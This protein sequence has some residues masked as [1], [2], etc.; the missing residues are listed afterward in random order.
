MGVGPLKEEWLK[1]AV[2]AN[3]DG[4]GMLIRSQDGTMVV[5]RGFDDNTFVTLGSSFGEQFDVVVHARIGTSG[6]RNIE[7]LHPFP[8][9]N[10]RLLSD[11]LG[12]HSPQ[13][14]L[15]HNGVVL[16]PLWNK[17]M[18]DTWHLARMWESLYGGQLKEKMRHRGWRRRQRKM[19][20]DY[21]KFVVVNEEGVKIINPNA[22][23]WIDGTWHSNKTAIEP[24]CRTYWTYGICETEDSQIPDEQRTAME[25]WMAD[26][27]DGDDWPTDTVLG[28]GI[29]TKQEDGTWKCTGS[30]NAGPAAGEMGEHLLPPM[31]EEDI[32]TTAF[33]GLDKEDVQTVRENKK[34]ADYAQYKEIEKKHM[35]LISEW[36]TNS[37]IEDIEESIYNYDAGTVALS[38]RH[39]L[40]KAGYIPSYDTLLCGRLDM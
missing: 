17:E 38:I 3:A 27:N 6:Q 37:K 32:E 33:G 12:N 22:G 39:L 2:E 13:A 34:I 30:T 8:I 31:S 11:E 16:V 19:L 5:Q 4:W 26:E 28:N 10:R 18:S 25:K 21:N 23:F 24:P 15:F 14:Y 7:N 35:E 9:Y 20:G 29:W 36:Q 1:N 40:R